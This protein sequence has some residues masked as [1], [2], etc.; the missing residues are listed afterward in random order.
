MGFDADG[1]GNHNFDVSESYLRN[2][3]IP[4]A[5]FPYFS[6]NIVVANGTTPAEWSPS[7]IFSFGERQARP[8]RV[9]ERGHPD[10]APS[11]ARSG[12]STSRTPTAAGQRSRRPSSRRGRTRSWRWATT[13]RPRDA[14]A[15]GAVPRA[16]DGHRA[17]RRPRGRRD[18]RRR[19]DRRPHRLPGDRRTGR[20]A[21]CWSRTAAR[22]SGSTADQAGRRQGSRPGRLQDRRLPQAVEHRRDARP[23]DPGA[24]RRAQRRAAADPRRHDRRLVGGRPSSDQCGRADGRLCESKVGNFV[25][26]AMR[27]DVPDRLRDHELGRACGPT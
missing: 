13:A 2:E 11:R 10:P 7:G 12:R 8:D 3:L 26:D 6:A 23:G 14:A 4:R 22:A 15:A 21:S 9:L 24:D 5:D 19:R 16:R 20:T 25:T 18:Q 17:G 27:D 1:L